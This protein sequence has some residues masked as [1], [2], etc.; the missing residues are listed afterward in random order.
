MLSIPPRYFGQTGMK[1]PALGLGAGHIGDPSQDE[2]DISALLNGALDL[3]VTFIDTAHGYGLSEERIGRH[4]AHRRQEFILSTKVGYGVPGVPDWTWSA[5]Y[6]GIEQALTRLKTDYLDVVYLHSCSTEILLNQG[7]IE[8]LERAR[9][10][11][12]VRLIGYA[13]DGDPRDFAIASGRLDTVLSSVNAFDQQ[14]VNHG[15]PQ[16]KDAGLGIVAKRP[17]GNVPWRFETQPTGHYAEDYWLRMREMGLDFGEEWHET[18]LRF[19]VFTW[20]VDTA[21]VGTSRLEHLRENVETVNKGML[22]AEVINEI[23]RA[24]LVHGKDWE[25]LV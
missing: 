18:A 10:H 12:K 19:T 7:V 15:L 4:L 11:G 3:G 16:A 2:S 20:G 14:F 5:V 8:A 24:F 13:G 17:L 22:D 25:G 23:R 9:A 21:I 1:V 6:K